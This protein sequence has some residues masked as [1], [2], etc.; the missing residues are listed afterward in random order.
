MKH[1]ILF[2]LLLVFINSKKGFNTLHG[3]SKT[4]LSLSSEHLESDYCESS[5]K[6]QFLAVI[7]PKEKFQCCFA[8]NKILGSEF[9]IQLSKNIGIIA[10]NF[11]IK[12][13]KAYVLEE[14]GY[15]RYKY[16]EGEEYDEPFKIDV[17]YECSYG[18]ICLNIEHIFTEKEKSIIKNENHFLNLKNLK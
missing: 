8:N 4:L 18:N 2:C 12:E 15:I 10:S 13:F 1:K 16:E 6:D 7:I 5:T 9:C 11:N 14:L 3:K 17:N